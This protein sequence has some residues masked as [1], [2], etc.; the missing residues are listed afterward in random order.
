MDSVGN[1]KRKASLKDM[2]SAGEGYRDGFSN[3]PTGEML[4]WGGAGFGS[5]H[6]AFTFPYY[7]QR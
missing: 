5:S 7:L 4:D 1:G 2:Y 6:R 3:R